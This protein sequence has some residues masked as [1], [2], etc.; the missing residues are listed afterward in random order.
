M[1]LNNLRQRHLELV[2]RNF[3]YQLNKNQLLIEF[4]FLLKPDIIFTPNIVVEPFSTALLEKIP[5]KRLENLIFNLGLAELPSYWKCACPSQITVEAGSLSLEQQAWWHDLFIKGMGEFYYK[6]Q[7][8]FTAPNFLNFAAPDQN[9]PN[10]PLL[11]ANHY[12]RSY[13]IPVGGGKDSS[14]TLGLLNQNQIPYG[15]LILEPASPAATM[16]AQ[17]SNCREIIRIQRTID[18]KLLELNQQGYLNGHTPFSSY[19]SF[20]STLIAQI[21]GFQQILVANERSANQA[22]LNYLGLEINHQ[23]SKSFE[24]EQKFRTY[25]QAYLKSGYQQAEYLSFLRPIYELQVAKLFSKFD[26]YFSLFRSCNLAQQQHA[27]CHQCAKCLFVYTLLY[28]FI[29]TQILT[30]K[31]FNYDLFQDENLVNLALQLVGAKASKPFECVGTYEEVRASFYLA[32]L[33]LQQLSQP[34]PIVV[35]KVMAELL[36]SYSVQELEDLSQDILQGWNQE[37]N[38]DSKLANILQAELNI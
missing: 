38:L 37:H 27:W 2:Y 21:F 13:L 8:N 11:A 3:S 5:K 28:P 23:Y 17:A 14:L 1:K 31:I 12:Q 25:A 15:C 7:I 30:T 36:N 26:S 18:P 20:A 32:A 33:K 19:L 10:L 9:Q 34:F 4:N 22:N 16:I 35:E 29:D 24:Y 6:N